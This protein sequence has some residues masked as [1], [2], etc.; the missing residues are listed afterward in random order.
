MCP[1]G[2]KLLHVGTCMITNIYTDMTKL[3]FTF[4]ALVL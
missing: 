4:F 2:N 3:R 1:V